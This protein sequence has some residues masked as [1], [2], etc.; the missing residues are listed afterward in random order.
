MLFFFLRR[1]ADHAGRGARRSRSRCWPRAALLYFTGRTL[2]ILSMMG[3]MLA[4]GMLVDN[5][6]VVLESI[7]RQ[8]SEG[9][10]ALRAALRGLA[11]GAAGGGERRPC[12]S[13][14]VFLPLVLGGR[15]EITTWIGEVGRTIIFTLLCSLF[16]SLTAIPLAMGRF[17]PGGI[18]RRAPACSSGSRTRHQRVLELDAAPP[19]GDRRPSRFGSWSRRAVAPV[20]AGGQERVHRQP[21]SRRC[22]IEYEFADNLN[23]PRGRAVRHR[24]SRTGSR[25]DKDSLHVKSTYSYFTNNVALTRAYLTDSHASDDGAQEVREWT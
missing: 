24:G 8:R 3:L 15:T 12:T 25:R 10:A 19:A 16:L 23:S 18:V 9:R 14:I 21:R 17:L 5:A 22:S 4:V 11:R 13:I 20:H 1:L 6:V 2:N 7:Y